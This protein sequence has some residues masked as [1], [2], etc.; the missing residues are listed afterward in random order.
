MTNGGR[1]A[2]AVEKLGAASAEGELPLDASTL[3]DE[4][5]D[6]VDGLL[7]TRHPLGF[8]HIDLSRLAPVRVDQRAR[9]HLWTDESPACT[10]GLGSVH[11]HV[12]EGKSTVLAGCLTNTFLQTVPGTGNLTLSEVS[13]VGDLQY[14][15]VIDKNIGLEVVDQTSIP[16][17]SW[18]FLPPRVIHA[19][20]IDCY[21]TATLV[22][23]SDVGSG[24]PRL[25]SEAHPEP[26][27]R[28]RPQIAPERVR[29]ALAEVRAA[30]V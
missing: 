29:E 16:A 17:G 4:V 15:H 20:Q 22:L 6:R 14:L 26:G 19:T 23:T 2:W 11:D 9:L 13:Y 24:Q 25:V 27:L 30:I 7:A 1:I 12:W 10:D 3:L 5:A 8:I 21:P 28:R 18:Y